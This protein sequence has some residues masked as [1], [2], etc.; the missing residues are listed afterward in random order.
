MK[1]ATEEQVI[2]ACRRGVVSAQRELYDRYVDRLYYVILRYVK[3]THYAENVLQDVFLKVFNNIQAYEAH[4]G[5][6]NT[7]VSTIAVREAI[8]HFKK[9]KLDF[10]P[11][12]SAAPSSCSRQASILSILEAEEIMFIIGQIPLKYRVI[13]NLY[14]IDGYT[15]REIADL[16]ELSESTSR[17]YLARAKGMIQ[18]KVLD[19]YYP[20]TMSNGKAS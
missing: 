4:K 2:E 10:E 18:Q 13:F 7:W 5:A 9:R 15:H 3:D 17:S 12:E 11:M 1:E 19:Y 6:F 20:K 16:L 14:D 8:N